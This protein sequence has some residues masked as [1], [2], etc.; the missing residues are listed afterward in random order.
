MN[1]NPRLIILLTLSA[2]LASYIMI[3]SEIASAQAKTSGFLGDYS[4]L[5]PSTDKSREGAMV[6]IKPG[7]DLKPYKAVHI[8]YPL[9]Q[10][11]SDERQ[12][13]VDPRDLTEL[14]SYFHDKMVAALEDNYSIVDEPGPGVLVVRTAIVDVKPINSVVGAIGKLA[15]KVVNLEI[16]SASIEA[17]LVDGDTGERLAALVETKKGDRVGAGMS[18]AKQW[19]HAKAAFK[20][21]AEVLAERLDEFQLTKVP[22]GETADRKQN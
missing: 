21:W 4:Q 12:S 14:A 20:S 5:E 19:G 18:G 3:N 2:V 6:Y 16:G 8:A 17:E 1:G 22:S 11:N 15:L 10:L 13:T 7:L 9:V